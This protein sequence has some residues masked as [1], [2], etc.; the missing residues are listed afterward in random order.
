MVCRENVLGKM[1][2]NP[3]YV[4][5]FLLYVIIC[6]LDLQFSI[7]VLSHNGDVTLI[8]GQ[9]FELPIGEYVYPFSV[10]L[11]NVLS[12]TYKGTH[13]GVTYCGKVKMDIPWA[14][15]K[16]ERREFIVESLLN[17]NDLPELNVFPLL[18]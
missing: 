13:G 18:H 17:L 11:P 4:W 16:A 15:D 9:K 1:S 10:S 5:N 12:S 6:I 2:Y 14:P 3:I 7:H 8:A